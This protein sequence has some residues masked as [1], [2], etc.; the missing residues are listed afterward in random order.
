MFHLSSLMP[1]HMWQNAVHVHIVVLISSASVY[2]H[3][4]RFGCDFLWKERNADIPASEH[5]NSP[6]SWVLVGTLDEVGWDSIHPVMVVDRKSGD[7]CH[8][9]LT[10]LQQAANLFLLIAVQTQEQEPN[11]K[12]YHAQQSECYWDEPHR[13]TTI[14]DH[15]FPMRHDQQKGD[16]ENHANNAED[17]S[18]VDTHFRAGASSGSDTLH[19]ISPF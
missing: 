9:I 19:V 6:G 3:S 8:D 14:Y 16:N 15:C 13:A 2:I 12:H 1:Y 5:M 7:V 10:A 18:S 4:Y 11:D 17:T